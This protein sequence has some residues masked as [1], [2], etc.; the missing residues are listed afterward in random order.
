LCVA[1]NTKKPTKYNLYNYKYYWKNDKLFK[2]TI[3]VLRG[4]KLVYGHP[5]PGNPAT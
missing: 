4:P 2:K 1:K 3:Y 5:V